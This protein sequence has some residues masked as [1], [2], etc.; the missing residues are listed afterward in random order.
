M[1]R[2]CILSLFISMTVSHP[3]IAE[4]KSSELNQLFDL[5]IDQLINMRASGPTRTLKKL[6]EVP[7]SVTVF[8][9]SEIQKMG[10]DFLFE[11]LSYVPGFQTSRD[12][13]YGGSYFYSSRGSDTGQDT[14]A[15]LL[16][17]NGSPRQEIR[18]ASASA[19]SSL[20]PIDR[21][22]RIEVIRGPGSALY[23]SGAFLGIINIVT[24]QGHNELKMQYGDLG[25]KNNQLQLSEQAGDWSLDAFLSYYKD[26]GDAYRLDDAININLQKT[27]DPQWSGNYSVQVGFKDT[28]VSLEHL[29]VE[30]KD[31]YSVSVINND[32]NEQQS[33][34]DHLAVEQE[35]HFGNLG[36][37]LK[38]GYTTN[39]LDDMAQNT[40]PGRLAPISSPSSNEPLIGDIRFKAHQWVL[41]WLNDWRID[42]NNSAQFGIE[43]QYEEIDT[44]RILANFNLD[45]LSNRRYP[46]DS[47]QNVDIYSQ[48]INTGDRNELGVYAQLQ[49]QLNPKTEITLGAR[50]DD[51][52]DLDGQT[53]LR[54]AGTR[55]LNR[56]HYL[57]L[58]YGEAYRAPTLTQI[59]RIENLTVAPNP[60]L[61][62]ETIKTTEAVW[63]VQT[64]DYSISTSTFYNVIDNLID[65][66]GFIGTRRANVNLDR[67]YS[68]GIE[69]E[70]S[71]QM[72]PSWLMRVGLTRFFTLPESAS[73]DS[74]QLASLILN[75]QR[76]QWWFN[77][78]GYYNSRR[79]MPNEA[80]GTMGGFTVINS[81]IGYHVTKVTTINLQIKNLFD[82]HVASAPQ[83]ESIYTPIP[84]R[85]RETSVGFN[86]AF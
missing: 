76:A 61:K 11:L 47:S 9:R 32:L 22:E 42:D 74:K 73:R 33:S 52:S 65:S 55:Q 23:G 5:S 78:S 7:A 14:T 80:D 62:P 64:A 66:S 51:Y 19:L 58:F 12:N 35:F 40:L 81:K 68:S 1:K 72:G 86:Y 84:Y 48:I 29:S 20:F 13:D 38:G 8:S 71:T 21:I 59:N 18:N 83:S 60:D 4:N 56:T 77:L 50:Y 82:A 53:S 67:A 28:K 31:Y 41:Q 46:V 30:S 24:V 43:K 57:K 36:M 2:I 26:D 75:Y 3:V 70:G 49:H 63:M 6:S 37:Q 34:S 45:M 39:R 15:I 10:V 54:L 16:M 27:K 25:R 44:G 69:I 17:I 79:D 85:G